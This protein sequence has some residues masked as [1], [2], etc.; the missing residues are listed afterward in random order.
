MFSQ[1]R[2]S[3]DIGDVFVEHFHNRR[4][5]LAMIGLSKDFEISNINNLWQVQRITSFSGFPHA[6]LQNPRSGGTRIIAV[7]ALEQQENYRK[8]D[9]TKENAGIL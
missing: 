5:I 3:V 7:D 4:R 6:E 9:P 8:I 2:V 1:K